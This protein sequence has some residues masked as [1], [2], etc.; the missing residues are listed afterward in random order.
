MEALEA[1]VLALGVAVPSVVVHEALSARRSL[2]M[3]SQQE[4]GHGR[5]LGKRGT[6]ECGATSSTAEFHR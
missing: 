3:S 5:S 2:G 4:G 6:G 1:V